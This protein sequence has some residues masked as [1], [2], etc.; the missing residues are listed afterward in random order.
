[1]GSLY[2]CRLPTVFKTVK[3]SVGFLRIYKRLSMTTWFVHHYDSLPDIDQDNRWCNRWKSTIKGVSSW[4]V[5]PPLFIFRQV[6]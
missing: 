3:M 1:M 5:F 4:Y 6:D 2:F